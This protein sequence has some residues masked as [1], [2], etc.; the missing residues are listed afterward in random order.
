MFATAHYFGLLGDPEFLR[1]LPMQEQKQ[2]EEEQTDDNTDK[3]DDKSDEEASDSKQ[4][5]MVEL[6]DL[7][8]WPCKLHAATLLQAI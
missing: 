4:T 2:S 1:F 5:A 8:E 7:T 6:D 3:S